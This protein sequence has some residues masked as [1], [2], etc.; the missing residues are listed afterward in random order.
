M[1]LLQ[2]NTNPTRRELRQFAGIWFPLA[3]VVI[4]WMIHRHTHTTT[5]PFAL[6]LIAL[7]IGIIGVIAPAVMKPIFVGWM[8]ASYPIGFVVS[9][10]VVGVIFFLVI[11]PV[12]LVMRLLGR[13]PL[14]RSFDRSAVTYWE[15]HNP[16]LEP[17]R[18]LRQF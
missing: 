13:D 3:F 16:G 1:A 18:Y 6:I 14:Q 15:E 10:V 9:H 4:A 11:T 8:Y 5:L 7:V 2:I 17:G 12:G